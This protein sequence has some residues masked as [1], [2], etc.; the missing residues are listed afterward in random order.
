MSAINPV[1][2]T[3]GGA[4]PVGKAGQPRPRGQRFSEV[5]SKKTIE[6]RGAKSASSGPAGDLLVR[7]QQGGRRLDHI[8][9]EARRGATYRPRQLLAMQAEVFRL[10]EE[11]SLINKVVEEGVSGVRRVWSMQI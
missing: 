5:L 3:T 6:P 9:A 4:S 2:L 11:I 1:S 10:S 8:I 7:L